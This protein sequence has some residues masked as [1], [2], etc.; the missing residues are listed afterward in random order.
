MKRSFLA[1]AVSVALAAGSGAATLA[2]AG[3]AQAAAPTSCSATDAQIYSPPAAALIGAPGTLIGCSVTALPLLSQKNIV[4]AKVQ[5][6]STNQS[7]RKIA[8]S[9]L[10]IV[11]RAAWA[12]TGTRPLVA[13]HPGTL[14]L[15][16]QCA[17]SKQ[18][19]GRFQDAYEGPNLDD[20]LTAGYAVAATDGVGYLDG[21]IHSYGIGANA[22]H[23]ILDIAR[24]ASRVPGS[25]VLPT[26]RVGIAG[27]SEGGQASL[28]AAQLAVS[29]APE[30]N[31]VGAA[32]GGV[33]GN[34]TVTGKYL[35]GGPFAGFLIDAAVSLS[36]TY[37][38]LHLNS[39][40]NQ[41]GKE[42]LARART[43]CVLGTLA[44]FVGARFET[45]TTRGYTIDQLRTLAGSDGV[46]WG[47]VFDA[48][49]LAVG[50]G[51]PGSGAPYTV[52][53]PV[54]QYR[55][56]AE[57]IIDTKTENATRDAYCRAGITT[58]WNQLYPSEHLTTDTLASGDVV[59]WMG[60]RFAGRT[61][62]GNCWLPSC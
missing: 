14:G 17:L 4:A 46:T 19:A 39:L 56:L 60:D 31:V 7:G 24:V 6:A 13:F 2:V 1:T 28:W 43:L 34:L 29:Y 9:G 61:T 41:R 33:P 37:P 54:F 15:G 58:D 3:P 48:Q 44:A 42:V 23:P 10:V 18:L 22:G 40:L 35:N 21:Q 32:A 12:G 38:K 25:G 57:E 55:G 47:Q 50:I 27:Y 53:F 30:L 20:F 36:T 51:K 5:Y 62:G 16:S 59:K 45:L 8:A 11:P 26:T 52:A 49:T